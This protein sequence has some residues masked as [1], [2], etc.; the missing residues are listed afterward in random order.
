L[1]NP[2]SS[3]IQVLLNNMKACCGYFQEEEIM[4]SSALYRCLPKIPPR[5]KQTCQSNPPS[6]AE[7]QILVQL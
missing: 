3:T 6:A 4:I 1:F 5:G 7:P 2:D